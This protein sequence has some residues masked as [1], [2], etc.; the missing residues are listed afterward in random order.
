MA[1]GALPAKKM[2]L[3][4]LLAKIRDLATLTQ[5][6]SWLSI[7]SAISGKMDVCRNP[8]LYVGIDE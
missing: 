2:L 4:K 6:S 7:D 3:E 1:R 5:H 8:I